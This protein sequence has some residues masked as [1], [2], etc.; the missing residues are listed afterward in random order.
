[1][2]TKQVN[3]SSFI[4]TLQEVLPGLPVITSVDVPEVL[5]AFDALLSQARLQ[6]VEEYKQSL[7]NNGN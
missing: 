3:A 5:K 6:A 2:T 4:K 7:N 1:M